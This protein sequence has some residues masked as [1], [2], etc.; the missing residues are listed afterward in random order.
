MCI[1]CHNSLHIPQ[2]TGLITAT[3]HWHHLIQALPDQRT[4]NHPNHHPN[5]TAS[6]HPKIHKTNI[7]SVSQ[8]PSKLP[9][10]LRRYVLHLLE[11]RRA[12]YL[13]LDVLDQSRDQG[14]RIF[15][16]RTL[17][18]VIV[19]CRRLKMCVQRR[20]CAEYAMTEVTFVS[21]AV[22]C[23]L[24]RRILD[25]RAPGRPTRACNAVGQRD[26]GGYVEGMDGGCDLVPR[27]IVACA[28]FDVKSD[29]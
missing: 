19:V 15:A 4:Y 11:P 10:Q 21:G 27:N 29:R 22:E 17:E 23:L 26:G 18:L 12:A 25:H 28:G 6:L 2:Q 9:R 20:E 1:A 3:H 8:Q 7:F 5:A 13:A 24:G 16:L 14:E